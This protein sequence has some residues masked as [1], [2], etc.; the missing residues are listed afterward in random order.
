MPQG[1]QRC[2]L[3]DLGSLSR[4]MKDA[5]ELPVRQR[6]DGRPAWKQSTLRSRR[7]P[8]LPQHIEQ[9]WRQHHIAILAALAL[10]DA[11]HHLGAVDIADLERHHFGGAQAATVGEAQQ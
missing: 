6:I 1:V 4:Q 5:I 2:A 11:D 10:L 8:P 3:P 9:S 7:L